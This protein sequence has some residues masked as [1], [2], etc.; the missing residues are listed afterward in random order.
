MG[1][2]K[3]NYLFDFITGLQSKGRLTFSLPEIR[4]IFNVSDRAL[5]EAL[6]RLAAKNR[7]CSVRRNFYIIIP[8]E[9]LA[10]RV[11]P[12]ALFVDDMMRFIGKHYYAGLLSAAVFHGAVHQQPQEFFVVTVQPAH[13]RISVRGIAINFLI[14]SRIPEGLIE[15]KQTETGYLNVSNPALTAI[16]CIS[17]AHRI[18]GMGRAA[19]VIRDLVPALTRKGLVSLV[20]ADIPVPALQRLGFL[21]DRFPE[22]RELAGTLHEAL[23]PDKPGRIMFSATGKKTD[24]P[25]NRWNVVE[26]VKVEIDE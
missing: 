10:Q 11:L 13:R 25:V 24:G 5:K 22:G 23:S 4:P 1:H 17:Y 21:L 6:R 18:G 7:I 8:P 3:D 2:L 15:K 16:D 12:P 26:N 19:E 20:K 14:R 9:Y